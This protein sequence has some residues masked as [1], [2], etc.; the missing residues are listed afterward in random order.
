MLSRKR[1]HAAAKQSCEGEGVLLVIRGSRCKSPVHFLPGGW[2]LEHFEGLYEQ[3]SLP[4]HQYERWATV[5]ENIFFDKTTKAQACVHK[6][7]R[8][9][10]N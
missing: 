9:E 3:E 5:L 8:R 1:A 6:K 7:G 4:V 2:Q 10:V